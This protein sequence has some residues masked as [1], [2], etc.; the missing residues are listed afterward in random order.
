MFLFFFDGDC[1]MF[2][3]SDKEFLS[4]YIDNIM[5]VDNFIE[6]GTQLSNNLNKMNIDVSDYDI[7]NIEI[8]LFYGSE[9]I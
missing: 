1:W 7:K 5:P 9:K 6:L 4:N 3:K 2:A 8:Y